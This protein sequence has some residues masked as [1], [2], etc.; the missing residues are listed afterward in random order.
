MDVKCLFTPC[1]TT[2]HICYYITSTVDNVAPIVFTGDTLFIAGCGRFFEGN[3]T[4]MYDALINKLS[5][6]PGN[7][8]NNFFYYSILYIVQRVKLR[9]NLVIIRLSSVLVK[10]K[11]GYPENTDKLVILSSLLDLFE[12]VQWS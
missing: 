6:L 9:S 3:A 10:L 4:Q 7:T 12:N 8:V 11:T 5:K 2:G 1:H